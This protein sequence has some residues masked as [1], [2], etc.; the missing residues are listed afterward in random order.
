MSETPNVKVQEG[1]R[2]Q[3]AQTNGQLIDLTEVNILENTS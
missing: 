2:P 1:M 3:A